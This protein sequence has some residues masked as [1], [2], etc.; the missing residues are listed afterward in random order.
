MIITGTLTLITSVAYWY[1]E[2]MNVLLRM[3]VLTSHRFLFPDSPTNAWFLTMEERAMAVK[4]I[5]ENQTGVENKHFKSEQ[6]VPHSFRNS[7]QV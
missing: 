1:A 2:C 4:R 6:C 7:A 3:V 5:Q